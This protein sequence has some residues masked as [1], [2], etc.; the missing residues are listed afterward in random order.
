[1]KLSDI[2]GVGKTFERDFARIGIT[3]VGQLNGE[4]PDDI[5]MLLKMANDAESHGT[6]KNDLYVIRMCVYYAN[7]GRDPLKLKWNQWKD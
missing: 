7:G 1:M 3:S 2:P 4:N 5:F 6:S